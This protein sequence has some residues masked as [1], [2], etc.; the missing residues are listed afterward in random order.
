MNPITQRSLDRARKSTATS[1]TFSAPATPPQPGLV[2]TGPIKRVIEREGGEYALEVV[3]AAGSSIRNPVV[4][5]VRIPDGLRA[6][7]D[8]AECRLYTSMNTV[9]AR[10]LRQYLDDQNRQQLLL[11]ALVLAANRIQ[12]AQCHALQQRVDY[13]EIECAAL[14]KDAARYKWLR[15]RDLDAVNQSGVFAG[16]TPLNMVLNCADLDQTVEAAFNRAA[17]DKGPE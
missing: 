15:G 14:A 6:E 2:I 4:F 3:R 1:P 7:I 12:P 16:E 11:D 10:A 5:V 13:L 8:S 17:R 9:F